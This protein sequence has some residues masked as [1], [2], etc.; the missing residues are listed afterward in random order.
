[1]QTIFHTFQSLG[2]SGVEPTYDA[3][4]MGLLNDGA[5]WVLGTLLVVVVVLLAV[6]ALMWIAGKL[7]GSSRAQDVGI[8]I[9]LWTVLGAIVIGGAGGLISWAAGLD[10]FG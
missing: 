9:L 2:P 7:G 10:L 1:M 3:P 8:T 4:W 5:G 6:G